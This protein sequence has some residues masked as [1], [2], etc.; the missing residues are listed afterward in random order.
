MALE[1]PVEFLRC[2]RRE[3]VPERLLERVGRGRGEEAPGAGAEADPLEG[4]GLGVEAPAEDPDEADLE[5]AEG[6]V[7][8]AASR[9]PVWLL[10]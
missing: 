4:D 8:M 9:E 6:D 7:G 10:R 3:A 1:R 2:R 5:D